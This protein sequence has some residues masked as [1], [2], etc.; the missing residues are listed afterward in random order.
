MKLRQKKKNLVFNN[1]EIKYLDI[2]NDVTSPRKIRVVYDFNLFIYF[3]NK[4]YTRTY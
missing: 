4:I 3:F 1:T 2:N